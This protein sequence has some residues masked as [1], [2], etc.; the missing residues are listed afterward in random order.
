MNSNLYIYQNTDFLFSQFDFDYI[1]KTD[2]SILGINRNYQIIL[3]NEG[4]VRFANQ[5]DG[6]ESLSRYGL[7]T[8]ILDAIYGPQKEY[9]HKFINNCFEQTKHITHEYECSSENVY[10]LMKL[11]VYPSH[12]NKVLLMEHTLIEK[13]IHD[14][15][16]SIK[17]IDDYLDND[18]II[19]QCGQCRRSQHQK[20]KNWDWVVSSFTH[21][22]ISHG[23][24]DSCLALYYPDI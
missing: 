14:I 5:N 20:T 19:I 11:F 22:K 7:G 21:V 6:V 3:F 16:E 17:I 9:Y 18:N 15:I 24:C 2:S 8:N 23:L 13:K 12:D 10:R 4:Y 1:G